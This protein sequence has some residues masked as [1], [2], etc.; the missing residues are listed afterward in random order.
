[1]SLYTLTLHNGLRALGVPSFVER[2]GPKPMC[3]NRTHTC[4]LFLPP[5]TTWAWVW[6]G[7]GPIKCHFGKNLLNFSAIYK[8]YQTNPNIGK[9]SVVLRKNHAWLSKQSFANG[10]VCPHSVSSRS[11]YYVFLSFILY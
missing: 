11:I 2:G 9:F 1:M 10:L 6:V 5:G 8:T 4:A 3:V 7:L